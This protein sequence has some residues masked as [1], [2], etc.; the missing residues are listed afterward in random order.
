MRSFVGFKAWSLIS[1]LCSPN[2][3]QI[4]MADPIGSEDHIPDHKRCDKDRLA[5]DQKALVDHVIDND[6]QVLVRAFDVKLLHRDGQIHGMEKLNGFL[7]LFRGRLLQN[8]L[9]DQTEGDLFTVKIVPG[10]RDLGN[11]TKTGNAVLYA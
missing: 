1:A 5:V 8:E 9:T 7:N 11:R 3:F 2:F 10:C 4:F 6:V